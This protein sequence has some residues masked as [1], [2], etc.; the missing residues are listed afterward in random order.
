MPNQSEPYY[1][2]SIPHIKNKFFCAPN[3]NKF[4]IKWN[5]SASGGFENYEIYEASYILVI[6][7][8]TSNVWAGGKGTG[9]S[10]KTKKSTDW[11]QKDQHRDK[12]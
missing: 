2:G 9:P 10:L 12:I 6:K 7:Y 1:Y 11:P 3:K 5:L 8:D 4:G